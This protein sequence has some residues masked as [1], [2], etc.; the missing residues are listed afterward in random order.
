MFPNLSF[1]KEM[2]KL[3]VFHLT[4]NVEDGDLSLC[5]QLPY[6]R[7]Q[8]RRHYSHKDSELPDDYTDPDQIIPF[9]IV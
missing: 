2:P 4:M 5:E 1:L 3:K 6:A 9:E 7:V 8:N